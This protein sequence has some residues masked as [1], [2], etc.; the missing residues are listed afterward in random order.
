MAASPSIESIRAKVA[1]ELNA[2]DRLIAYELTSNVPLIEQI[3]RY[4]IQC[5]GKRI[6]PLLLLLSACACGYSSND[7]EHHE[8]ALVIEFIHTAT[9]LHDDVVDNSDRRRGASTA[10]AVWGNSASVLVGDFLYSRA[11]QILAR[12]DNIPVMRVLANTTNQIA[13]GEMLQLANQHSTDTSIA[14]YYRVI[15]AKTASLFAAASEI[16]ARLAQPSNTKLHETFHQLG[17]ELGMAFQIIDDLLDYTGNSDITGKNLGDDLQ[18]GKITLPVIYAIEKSGPKTAE[19]LKRILQ[20][21]N[22]EAFDRVQS[23]IQTTKAKEACEET[24]KK[25]LAAATYCLE[26]LPSSSYKE[27]IIDLMLFCGARLN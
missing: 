9:L 27:A 26:D 23:A 6:R 22:K 3:I 13:E 10:N 17:Q 24:A 5:G 25:H 21:G 14:N 7:C 15:H 19:D 11:F 2:V 4:V 12:R 1:D 18:E 8:L 20:Q 16:G